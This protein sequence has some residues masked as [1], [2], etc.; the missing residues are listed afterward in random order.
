MFKTIQSI[1]PDCGAFASGENQHFSSDTLP[2]KL[3][4]ALNDDTR[5]RINTA[6]K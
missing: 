3:M 2:F 1:R 6:E 4:P 5:L